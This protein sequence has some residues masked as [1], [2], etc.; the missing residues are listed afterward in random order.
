MLV[1]ETVEL[2]D[3]AVFVDNVA[4]PQNMAAV[5]DG[6]TTV[7]TCTTGVLDAFQLV[8]IPKSSSR[9]VC[10]DLLLFGPKLMDGSVEDGVVKLREL[11]AE[12]PG[13]MY[14]S[15]SASY[16]D[17]H[18][19]WFDVLPWHRPYVDVWLINGNDDEFFREVPP[20][21]SQVLHK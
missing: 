2:F 9:Y 21:G 12:S 16:G 15:V 17:A 11:A 20:S 3:F 1:F 19:C 7:L 6:L 14:G 18:D 4:L 5:K 13:L 8:F 10:I